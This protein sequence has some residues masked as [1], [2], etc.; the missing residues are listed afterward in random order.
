MTRSAISGSY[1]IICLFYRHGRVS[2]DKLRLYLDSF[3]LIIRW[4]GEDEVPGLCD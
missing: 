4:G 3:E 1:S 2:S